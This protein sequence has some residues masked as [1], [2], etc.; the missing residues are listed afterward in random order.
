[1]RTK[2]KIINLYSRKENYYE[3]YIY[4]NSKPKDKITVL[5]DKQDFHRVKHQ[6][7]SV[8]S[9]R[10]VVNAKNKNY[11]S[12]VILN[13]K[14]KSK[15]VRHKVIHK[16]KIID[17]RRSNLKLIECISFK[18]K[19]I[20][21]EGITNKYIVHTGFRFNTLE[22]AIKVRDAIWELRENL[23]DK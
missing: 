3:L 10:Y 1:M 11:M 7:W 5:I 9:N 23:K 19:G 15:R 14:D 8:I 22:E 21:Y 12:K 16:N 17:N 2:E 13:V 20:H 18:E 6:Q 4:K